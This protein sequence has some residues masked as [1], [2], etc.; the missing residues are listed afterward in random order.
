MRLRRIDLEQGDH[1]GILLG[2]HLEHP[3]QQNVA[4]IDQVVAEQHRERLVP[5]V[6]LRPQHGVPQP[7]RIALAQVV[8]LGKLG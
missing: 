8:H 4:G 5:H 3:G 2:L 1:G 7:E 6:H